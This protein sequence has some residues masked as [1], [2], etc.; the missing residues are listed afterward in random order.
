MRRIVILGTG[1]A[2]GKTF[3]SVAIA[4]AL[5]EHDPRAHVLA[6]KPV[7]TGIE[8]NADGAPPP[9]SD[10]AALESVAHRCTPP[11]P[12]PFYAFR[13]PVSP[14]RAA[15]PDDRRV[16]A[17]D[18]AETIHSH[19]LHYTAGGW[20]IVETAGGAFSP[21]SP[22]ET[23]VDLSRAL[24]PNALWVLVAPD[25]LGVIHD[26]VAT[27][28]AMRAAG[29]VPDLLLLCGARPPDAS[30]GGNAD[31]LRAVGLTVP[32]VELPRDAGAAPASLVQALVGATTGRG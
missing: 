19:T 28:G 7:E 31:E 10:A 8:R 9:G 1:T 22:N 4:R 20:C 13:T 3:A 30:T 21:L 27:T 32:I 5:V 12:H 11:R 29:R 25:S 2:V 14:F 18:I 23:N 15:T 6:L 16:S 26:V 24:G 17:T